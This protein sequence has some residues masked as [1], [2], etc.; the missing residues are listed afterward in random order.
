MKRKQHKPADG[1]DYVEDV[2]YR[3]IVKTAFKKQ[4]KDILSEGAA[5]IYV[6]SEPKIKDLVIDIVKIL[7]EKARIPNFWKDKTS[8]VRKLEGTIDDKLEFCGIASLSDK[9]EKI[10]AEILKLAEKRKS[11]LKEEP[12]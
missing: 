9:H 12:E 3:N 10:C 8:G 4:N 5:A 1:L 11:D 2:F 6:E 7:R